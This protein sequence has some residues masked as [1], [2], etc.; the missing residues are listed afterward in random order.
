MKHHI[1]EQYSHASSSLSSAVSLAASGTREQ[2]GDELIKGIQ[3]LGS[4]L[5]SVVGVAGAMG[6]PPPAGEAFFGY[7]G[8]VLVG[9][10]NQLSTSLFR[11]MEMMDRIVGREVGGNYVKRAAENVAKELSSA[12][13]PLGKLGDEIEALRGKLRPYLQD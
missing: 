13:V 4:G 5:R 10:A 1:D 6:P 3:V 11:I 12:K 7:V 8:G 9:M 2:L